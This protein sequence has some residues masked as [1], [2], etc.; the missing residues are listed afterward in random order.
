MTTNT[1]LYILIALVVILIT[2]TGFNS[3]NK[4]EQDNSQLI[5]MIEELKHKA[6]SLNKITLDTMTAISKRDSLHQINITNIFN[7]AKEKKEVYKPV[8]NKRVT[9]IKWVLDSIVRVNK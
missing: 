5:Q 9:D 4:E 6:D 7:N 1:L 2:I 3:C 8:T